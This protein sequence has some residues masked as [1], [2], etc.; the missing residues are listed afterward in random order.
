MV[1][2]NVGLAQETQEEVNEKSCRCSIS[3]DLAGE[4]GKDIDGHIRVET[5]GVLNGYYRIKDIHS[6]TDDGLNVSRNDRGLSRLNL[7]FG[8]TVEVLPTVPLEDKREAFPRGDL[9]ETLWDL[10]DS[11]IFISCPHGGDVEYNTDEMGQYLFKQLMAEG[12]PSTAWILHG[13]YS[14]QGKDATKRWHVNKPIKG[15]DAYPGLKQLKEENRSFRYGIGFHIQNADHVG[16]GGMADQEIR[17]IVAEA[18]RGP[19]PSKYDILTDY[20]E[21]KLTG[22]GTSMSMNHFAEDYQGIQIEMP[23]EV[24][25][26]KFHSLPEKVADAFAELL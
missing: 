25:F 13:Y 19:V 17:D 7:S 4:L 21:M 15:Y 20:E 10:D 24:A 9:A 18:I 8:D 26:N 6:D 23:K 1:S 11:Q 22:K 3:R 16:V 12:I 5:S 2:V 14:G